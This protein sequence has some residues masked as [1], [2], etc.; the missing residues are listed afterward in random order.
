M[1]VKENK[2]KALKKIEQFNNAISTCLEQDNITALKETYEIRD[3]FIHE[4]FK[5]YSTFLS[6]DDELYFEDLKKFD[7]QVVST[8]KKVKESIA[9]EISFSKK[10]RTGINNY[11]RIAKEK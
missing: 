1:S 5:D 3:R 7:T 10:T 11:Q 2:L 4:F 9:E 6:D 8:I